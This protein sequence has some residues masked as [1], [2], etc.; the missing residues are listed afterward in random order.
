MVLQ[1]IGGEKRAGRALTR[2]KE[3]LQRNGRVCW[4]KEQ[5]FRL[6]ELCFCPALGGGE[7]AYSSSS[8]FE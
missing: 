6:P 5:L 2:R 1:M 8:N 7:L 4:N 3:G